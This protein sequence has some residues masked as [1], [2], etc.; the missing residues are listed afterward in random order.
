MIKKM[1]KILVVDD[2]E[3]A[4]NYHSYILRIFE[5]DV[6]TAENGVEA[7]E[8]VLLYDYDLVLTDINMP[9]MDGYEFITKVRENE[10]ETPIVIVSTED[11]LKIEK[12]GFEK[13][14]NT[15]LVKPTD[16]EELVKKVNYLL[17]NKE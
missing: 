5:Y 4:R 13:G 7:L 8:K 11:E 14:A 2:S 16:P 6:S 10:I 15:Y 1:K 12:N 17:K 9:K 3:I